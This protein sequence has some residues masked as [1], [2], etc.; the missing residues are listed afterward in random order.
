MTRRVHGTTGAAAI[1]A[2]RPFHRANQPNGPPPPGDRQARCSR[3][4]TP[5]SGI[6][7]CMPQAPSFTADQRFRQFLETQRPLVLAGL[8]GEQKL[9]SLVKFVVRSLFHRRLKLS[10]AALI[11]K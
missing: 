4:E 11:K 5:V 9:Q 1:R 2:Q 6:T 10:A 8:S 7:R 3:V